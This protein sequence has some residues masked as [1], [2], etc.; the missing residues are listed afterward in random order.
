MKKSVI[1]EGSR[2][3]LKSFNE[4]YIT[5]KY[6]N[7]LKN[8]AINKVI[9]KAE[10]DITLSEIDRYCRKLMDSEYDYFFAIVMD[11]NGQHI[12]NVRIGPI[13]YKKNETKFGMMIGNTDYHGQGIGSEA[14]SLCVKFCF[15]EL[16]INKIVLEVLEFNKA[17]IRIYEKNGFETEK[18]LPNLIYNNGE[19]MSA[20][21]MAVTNPEMRKQ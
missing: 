12:G 10:P 1:I 13:D 11:K 6:V 15:N 2:F 5:D 3:K 17:A 20:R 19:Y 9:V 4:K 16:K 8:K 7:W 21:I 14:V 18:M